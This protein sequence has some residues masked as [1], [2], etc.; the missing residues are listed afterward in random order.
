M[1]KP[2][3]VGTGGPCGGK[4]GALEELVKRYGQ[5]ILVV[6]ESATRQFEA[7]YP[8]IGREV[9][10]SPGWDHRFQR[11]CFY[12]GTGVEHEH[13]VMAEERPTKIVL[14]DRAR[15]E[16]A[17]YLQEHEGL[18]F[19][20]KM[21]DLDLD[22]EYARYD[23][24]IHFESVAVSNPDLYEKLKAT[25][26][27][28]YENAAQAAYRDRRIEE[29][30]S[31]HPNWHKIS[32]A[33][34]IDSVIQQVI[35][36]ISPYLE[37]EIESKFLLPAMPNIPLGKGIPVMQG[38]F[39]TGCEMRIRRFGA[40]HYITIK[41]EGGKQRSECER[42]IT[43]SAFKSLW[44]DT[45]GRRVTKIR[46]LISYNHHTL[47]LDEYLGDLQGLVTLEC[48]FASE[49]VQA[50]FVLPDWAADAIDIS[51]DPRYK[52]RAL[53]LHGLPA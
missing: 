48:E 49:E 21:F 13:F 9:K 35:E 10:E 8:Q 36:L 43:A 41:S 45:N 44:P 31:G 24:V 32:G 26:P 40:E 52:N 15:L 1:T 22:E 51:E 28:R 16:G 53:A 5:Q 34:G 19:F 7:G 3:I 4:T 42:T 38:Y 27:V 46:H 23:M 17:A 12:F 25:N 50:T 37:T 33:N 20:L 6:P 2:R 29:V 18:P 30:W 14:L 39:D 47:E 11:S